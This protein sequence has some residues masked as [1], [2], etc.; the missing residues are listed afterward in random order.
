MY[1]KILFSVYRFLSHCLNSAV[2]AVF[3]CFASQ[4]DLISKLSLHQQGGKCKK[5]PAAD[6]KYRAADSSAI[7]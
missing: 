1:V 2:L 4:T 5:K 7:V 3:L 6:L